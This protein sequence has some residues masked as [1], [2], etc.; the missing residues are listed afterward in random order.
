MSLCLYV[1]MSLCVCVRVCVYACG[2]LLGTFARVTLLTL[3]LGL[4]LMV[5][6]CVQGL[7]GS[8]ADIPALTDVAMARPRLSGSFSCSLGYRVDVVVA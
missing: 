5:G 6:D 1:V 4:L 3:Q 2:L 7:R 8:R